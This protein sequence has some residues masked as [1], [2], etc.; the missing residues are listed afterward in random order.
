MN[1]ILLSV[2]TALFV[3]CKDVIS[4]KTL[5]DVHYLVV[6]LGLRLFALPFLFC[7]LFFIE[8][9]QI[10]ENF[11]LVLIS[12]GIMNIFSTI[13]YMRALNASDLSLTI[14]MISFSPLLLLITSPIILGEFPSNT[15]V[16][17]VLLIVTGSYVLNIKEKSKGYMQPLIGLLKQRGPRLMLIVALI[18][19]VSSN[20]DKLGI[21]NSSPMF[22]TI[23]VITFSTLGLIPIVMVRAGKH[24]KQDLSASTGNIKWLV[25]LGLI[26]SLT[27]VCQMNA[28]DMALVTYVISIKRS[29][30]VFSVIFGGLI[31]KEKHL[32]DRIIGAIIMT[33]GVIVITLSG[34]S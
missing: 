18:W 25:L 23:A 34:S 3:S 31:F 5:Q 33:I 17:G 21:Q 30:A 32:K 1:W 28:I 22:W 11:V 2:L 8:I 7:L 13:L 12:A 10:G 15:G 29:S 9:P 20:F 19:S 4:K 26:S 27:L 6:A 24:L 16:V 14:P